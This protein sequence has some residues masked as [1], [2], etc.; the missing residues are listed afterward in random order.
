MSTQTAFDFAPTFSERVLAV[1][2]ARKSDP[3]PS[4][5]AA[6]G[7]TRSGRREGQ[8]LAVLALVR[9]YPCSTSLEL[10]SNSNLDRYVIARRLPELEKAGYIARRNVRECSVGKRPATTWQAL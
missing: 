10:A 2:I 7:I 9:K 3:K 5:L 4:H 1:R 8:C 6:G